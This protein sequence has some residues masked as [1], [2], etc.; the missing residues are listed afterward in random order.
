MYT[1]VNIYIHTWW[2]TH[3]RTYVYSCTSAQIHTI[4]D[5]RYNVI[6]FCTCTC[7]CTKCR[8]IRTPAINSC[9]SK[10]IYSTTI[11]ENIFALHHS[12]SW[13]IYVLLRAGVCIY[14]TEHAWFQ[15]SHVHVHIKLYLWMCMDI[16]I[17]TH[18]NMYVYKF[19]DIHVN[20]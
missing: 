14:L 3:V 12:N 18:N 9:N 20:K 15:W 10:N 8:L 13:P 6:H 4:Y 1:H 19:V 17:R 7:N 2:Y 16:Y 11:Q 5:T